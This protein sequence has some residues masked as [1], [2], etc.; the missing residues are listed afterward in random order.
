M[1]GFQFIFYLQIFKGAI[2]LCV[3]NKLEP[4]TIPNIYI[5]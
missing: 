4:S 1:L 5:Y 3:T 2:E